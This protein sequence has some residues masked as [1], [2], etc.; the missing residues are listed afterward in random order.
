MIRHDGQR[1][2]LGG[3]EEDVADVV[4]RPTRWVEVE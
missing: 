2:R 1:G 3:S 4:Q